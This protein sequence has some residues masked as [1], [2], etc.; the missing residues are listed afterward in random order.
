MAHNITLMAILI[1]LVAGVAFFAAKMFGGDS[2][3][4]RKLI[5]VLISGIG[6]GLAATYISNQI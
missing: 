4:K 2:R 3:G 5:F 6:L 1:V